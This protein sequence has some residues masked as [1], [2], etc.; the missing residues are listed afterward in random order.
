MN[1]TEKLI[2]ARIVAI[3]RGDYRGEWLAYAQALIN[4]GVTAMEITMNSDDALNGIEILADHF[5]EQI[6][7]GAGTVLTADEVNQAVDAGA[8]FIVAPDTD[9]AV[10]AESKKRGVAVIPGAYTPSEIKRAYQLGADIVKVFP[11]QTPAYIKAVRAPLNHIPLMATGGVSMENAREFIEAGAH[12]LGLGS[13]LLAPSLS[14]DAV[15]MRA[16]GILA[17]IKGLQMV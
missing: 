3:F 5:G 8:R 14:P 15:Q 1:L 6:I 13:A 9:E 12:S 11:A 7:L 10:I 4:G 17:A 16:Q 2:D